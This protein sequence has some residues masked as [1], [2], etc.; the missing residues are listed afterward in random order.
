M[1]RGLEVIGT[2]ALASLA[3]REA[4][5]SLSLRA[6]SEPLEGSQSRVLRPGIGFSLPIFNRNAGEIKARTLEAQM[7][8][9]QGLALA[10]SI[11]IEVARAVRVYESAEAQARM[12]DSTVLAPAREN[13]RLLELA[14]REGKVGLPVLLLIRSQVLDAEA[15]YWDAWL[16]AREA[17]TD[18]RVAVGGDFPTDNSGA[19][20]FRQ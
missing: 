6:S 1:G 8:D 18:I 20:N 4:L 9:L 5:P 19:E 12:L 10:S 15:E 16:A 3:R 13:R 11:R 17:I 2:R 7:I 14:Y